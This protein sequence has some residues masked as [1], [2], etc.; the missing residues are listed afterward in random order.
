MENSNLQKRVINLG[1]EYEKM[2][3]KDFP[4][5]LHV[6]LSVVGKEGGGLSMTSVQGEHY[7]D[8][9]VSVLRHITAA[10]EGVRAV[11]NK[12]LANNTTMSEKEVNDLVSDII[13]M[14]LNQIINGRNGITEQRIY[15]L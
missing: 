1:G 12:V 3:K 9:C 5:A 7:Q 11:L 15:E 10:V 6:M 13:N 14:K 8:T 2:F 4:E